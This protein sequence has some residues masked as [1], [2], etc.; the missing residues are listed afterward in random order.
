MD[1]QE[2]VFEDITPTEIP[3]RIGKHRYVLREASGEVAGKY[4]SACL[5]GVEN[6]TAEDGTTTFRRLQAVEEVEPQLV[7]WCLYTTQADGSLRRDADGYPLDADRVSL[8]WVKRLPAHIQT[9]LFNKAIEISHLDETEDLDG[10]R[11]QIERLTKLLHRLEAQGNGKG[12]EA[13]LKNS[14]VATPA[15]SA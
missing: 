4:R 7:A 13:Y 1:Q 12:R 6:V 8:E 14:P 5:K 3:Y 10:L 2:I 9:A 15:G 11:K